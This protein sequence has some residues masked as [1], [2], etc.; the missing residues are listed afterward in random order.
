MCP[1]SVDPESKLCQ[2]LDTLLAAVLRE[3]ALW[4]VTPSFSS[5]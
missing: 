5:C 4:S 3:W 2:K 1:L